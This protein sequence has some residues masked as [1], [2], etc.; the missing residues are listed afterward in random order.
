MSSDPVVWYD[1]LDDL[2]HVYT[3]EGLVDVE[4]TGGE[5]RLAS[6]KDMGYIASEV[7]R[8]ES[9]FN[10]NIVYLD[11]IVPG[12]SS[13]EISILNATKEASVLGYAN[14]T[15]PGFAKK[16]CTE[17]S[18][19]TIGS[20]AFPEIRVQVNLNA[21]GTDRPRLLGWYLY[22]VPEGE[23]REEFQ[24]TSKMD[25]F[26]GIDLAD[27]TVQIDPSRRKVSGTPM[28]H[29]PY[30]T[31]AIGYYDANL[32]IFTSNE[33]GSSYRDR[34][35]VP[36]DTV[37][38]LEFDDLNGDGHYDLVVGQYYDYGIPDYT[39]SQIFWGNGSGEWG[40]AGA[41]DLNTY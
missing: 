5:A 2:S 41:T 28:G 32:N 21:N 16:V 24:G 26:W 7:I 6:G 31:V 40:P 18:L 33:D 13:I 4:V 17:R 22:F 39:D 30:P 35:Q 37:A 12:N 23:W 34:V 36:C 9:G 1:P 38:Y 15:V 19:T 14:E 29:D 3:P 20:V 8:A 11:A 27:G 10:Y 25:G